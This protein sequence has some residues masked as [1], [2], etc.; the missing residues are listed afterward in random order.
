VYIKISL[1][2]PFFFEEPIV[3]GSGGS[4]AIF[5]SHCNMRCVYCQNYAIS[6][7]GNGYFISM[8]RLGEIMNELET[9]GCQFINFVSPTPYI[10][11]LAAILTERLKN[12]SS[13][14]MVYNTNA[15]EEI[16]SLEML[17]TL[18]DVYLPDYKYAIPDL[19]YK[20]SGINDYPGKALAAI[21][22]MVRQTGIPVQDEEELLLQGTLVRHL[23]LPNYLD[24]SLL[25]LR[26]LAEHIPNQIVVSLMSQY[27]PFASA[28]TRDDLN[29]KLRPSE[30][31]HVIDLAM[32]LDAFDWFT[33]E[34]DSSDTF[35]IPKFNS[36]L[37]NHSF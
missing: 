29:R 32:E 12:P 14:R 9:R 33:Q 28:L 1:Y 37:S 26:I 13:V 23:V 27:T 34:L 24:N 25:A 7:D 11:V 8:A 20:L 6:Q 5:F 4:G 3:T 30:Y 10:P 36:F 21:M 35:Y 19:G 17:D 18:I 2:Q 31:Q 16:S 15:Y 22:E